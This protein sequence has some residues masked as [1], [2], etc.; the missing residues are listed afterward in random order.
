M[1]GTVSTD[2]GRV[3]F[4]VMDGLVSLIFSMS[5]LELEA[6]RCLCTHKRTQEKRPKSIWEAGRQFACEDLNWSGWPICPMIWNRHTTVVT[7][8][9]LLHKLLH[10]S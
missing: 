9:A 3:T 6:S 7:V 4:N 8:T 10:Q 1:V 2:Q 5:T